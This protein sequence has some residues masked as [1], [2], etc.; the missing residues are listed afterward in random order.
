MNKVK[1]S[2]ALATY[3]EEKNIV[4]CL[5]SLKNFADEVVIVDGS[6]TDRTAELAENLGAK[7]IKT[8]NKPMFHKN[9]NL[10]IKNCHGQWVFLIDADERVS[11]ELSS[12]IKK[13]VSSNPKNNGYWVNR[14]NWFLGDFLKKGGAY[15]DSVIRLFKNGK[16]ILPEVSVHEQIKIEG[17][18]GHLQNDLIHYA[19][20]TFSRYLYRAQRYIDQTALIIKEKNPGRSIPVIIYYLILKPIL[21]F[22]TIFIR[23]KGFVDGFRG[24]VWA[25]FSSS[26]PFYAYI[27]YYHKEV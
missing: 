19:D 3:N 25:L 27:K 20:P 9:K 18:I 7:V 6:S 12:E 24:F 23:H 10:A 22:V 26:Q 13:I 5:Q 1:I 4:D 17:L 15:P 8:T 11:P 21:T 14:R 16:G 2:S